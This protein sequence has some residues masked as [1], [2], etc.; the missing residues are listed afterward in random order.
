MY[1][2]KKSVDAR[3]KTR[4]RFVYAIDVTVKGDEAELIT[5]L[6]LKDAALVKETEKLSPAFHSS[7]KQP[8]VVGLGP[9]GLFAALY[10]AFLAFST[11]RLSTRSRSLP[12]P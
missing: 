12:R 8:V 3:D 10:L 7:S 9:C 4:L 5:Q 2:A 6:K 1:I 11:V